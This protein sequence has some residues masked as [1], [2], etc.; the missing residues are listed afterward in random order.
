MSDSSKQE[1]ALDH[2]QIRTRNL[3]QLQRD[4]PV[5]I[6]YRSNR[7]NNAQKTR[8]GT[9]MQTQ[10]LGEQTLRIWVYDSENN[11]KL[12]L[13]IGE[14]MNQ[15]TVRSQKTEKMS[16]IGSLTLLL[17]GDDSS[18]TPADV[19]QQHII[20]KRNNEYENVVAAAHINANKHV[21]NWFQT[22]E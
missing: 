15:S 1:T 22:Q 7:G 10:A 9:I 8:T 3:T 14:T 19:K 12:E 5:V 18:G 2:I 11:R 17:A 4:T 13:T 16:T 21:L 20:N 6:K